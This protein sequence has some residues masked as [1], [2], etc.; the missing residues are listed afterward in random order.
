MYCSLRQ[1]E[2]CTD[3]AEL[4]RRVQEEVLPQLR[5]MPGFHSYMVIDCLDGD[6]TSI[7]LYDTEDQAEAANAK[8][9]E[10]V[11]QALS[12]LVP[13]DPTIWLGEVIIDSRT[14]TE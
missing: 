11:A 1:Y 2:G 3:V 9:A 7:S 12:D 10:I 4:Q 6:L 8:A 5:D 14:Q 13:D